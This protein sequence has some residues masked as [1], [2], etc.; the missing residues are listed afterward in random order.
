MTKKLVHSHGRHSSLYVSRLG[1]LELAPD[2]GRELRVR[3]GL[4]QLQQGGLLLGGQVGLVALG[5][6]QQ[7]LVPQHG[8][9]PLVA[10]EG[11]EVGHQ[12]VQHAEGQRVLLVQHQAQ[13]DA[14][15]TVVVH[16][17]QL[18]HGSTAG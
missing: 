14:V 9:L 5:Q 18:Q 1:V 17:G 10:A 12:G 7:A 15:G 4:K 13:E 11:E 8:E 3:L 2:L 16:L 6:R